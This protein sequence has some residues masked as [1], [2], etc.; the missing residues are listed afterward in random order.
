LADRST[1]L[2]INLFADVGGS[3]VHDEFRCRFQMCD[4]GS[5]HRSSNCFPFRADCM[6]SSEISERRFQSIGRA[7]KAPAGAGALN[8]D[9]VAQISNSG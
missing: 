7:N 6:A 1:G 9:R 2:A 8:S 5:S 4:T 3:A